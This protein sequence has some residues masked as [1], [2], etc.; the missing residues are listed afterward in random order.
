MKNIYIKILLFSLFFLQLYLPVTLNAQCLCAGAVP[1]TPIQQTITI[2][3]TTIST[4]T[5]NFQQFDPTVGTLSCVSF[6]DTVTGS[7]I[8]GA[9]NT[10]PDSTAFLFSLNLSTKIAGPGILISHPFSTT[11]GYDVLA[12]FGIP[13]DS[14]T[15]GPANIITN[16]SGTASTGGNAAYV[17]TGTVPFTFAVNGG[18]VTLDGGANYISHVSTT[19]GGTMK[20]TYYYCPMVLLSTNLQNFSAFKKDNAVLL[21]WDAQNAETIDQFE[22]EYSTNGRDFTTVARIAGDHVPAGSYQYNYAL[23]NNNVSGFLYFRIRQTGSNNKSGYSAIQKISLGDKSTNGPAVY[24]NPAVTG[25]SLNFDHLLT[26]DY[27]IDLVNTAGQV[28]M[29]KKV[30][31]SNNSMIPMN[32]NSKP[33]P[34][35]YFARVTNSS[36]MERQI[37]R[38]VIQ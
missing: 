34:G 26:G 8:T 10:G 1:A 19:I 21:K 23:N 29:D 15:Y 24:P 22:I 9:R 35:I 3:P 38:V 27:H 4:L 14:I 20:L 6:A 16:P 2:P 17:G 31:L 18:M 37:A 36:T 11:Y 32:W 25:I 13:G 12:P 7:S 5:F 30:R 33:A 28:I